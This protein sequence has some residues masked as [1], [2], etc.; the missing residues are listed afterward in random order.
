[1]NDLEILLTVEEGRS[2]WRSRMNRP[3]RDWPDALFLL[4]HAV[5]S[6]LAS[7]ILRI[8]LLLCLTL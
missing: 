7:S 8:Y 1:M 3:A 4:I 6:Y 5:F 2:R